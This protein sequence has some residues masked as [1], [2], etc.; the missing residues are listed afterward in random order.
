MRCEGSFGKRGL[1]TAELTFHV[2]GAVR[3][4]GGVTLWSN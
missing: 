1:E 2:Y 3:E 4:P